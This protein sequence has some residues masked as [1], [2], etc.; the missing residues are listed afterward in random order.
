VIYLFNNKPIEQDQVTS[1]WRH[2]IASLE[3]KQKPTSITESPR[4]ATNSNYKQNEL[5]LEPW[6]DNPR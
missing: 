3:T 1:K 2:A 4:Q 6:L 5:N